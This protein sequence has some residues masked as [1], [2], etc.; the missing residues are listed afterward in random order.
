MFVYNI[1][2]QALLTDLS[3]EFI[4]LHWWVVLRVTTH[5]ASTDILDGHVLDVE[6]NIVAGLCLYQG[7]VVHLNGL[8]LSCQVAWS[9]CHNHAWLHDTSLNT[10]HRHCSNT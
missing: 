3:K 6:A 5:E 1:S 8:H 7:L 9:K 10:T 2:L 4:C